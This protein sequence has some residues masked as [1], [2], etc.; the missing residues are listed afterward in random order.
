[1]ARYAAAMSVNQNAVGYCHY[2]TPHDAAFAITF[3]PRDVDT[4]ARFYV[5]SQY[6]IDATSDAC[7]RAAC[8]ILITP[9]RYA[10]MLPR[11][12]DAL[13]RRLS[14]YR[15]FADA[16]R[17]SP[18]FSDYFSCAYADACCYAFTPRQFR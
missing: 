6:A 8:A 1:M 3:M 11:I 12:S 10:I 5:I 15:H 16:L 14:C 7:R 18:L 9:V 4:C 2:D 17:F 13:L